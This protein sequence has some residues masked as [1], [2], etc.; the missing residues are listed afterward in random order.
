VTGTGIHQRDN[1]AEIWDSVSLAYDADQYWRLPENKAN[2][3]VLLT[4]IGHAEGKQILEMGCGSGYTSMALAQRGAR[5]TLL[6]LSPEAL[7]VAAESFARAG[8]PPPTLVREDALTTTL[9]ANTFDIAWNGGV[10]EHFFDSGKVLLIRQMLRVVK[11]GGMVII[12]VPNRLC[13]YFQ[14]IQAWK[15]LRGTWRYG[16]ED[17]MSPGRLKR[18][19]LHAGHPPAD[20]YAY[21]PVV[22]WQWL[23]KIGERLTRVLG[24]ERLERH[25]QRVRTGFVTIAV[26]EKKGPSA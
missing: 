8:L 23:P 25:C 17:D 1:V 13:W 2:L 22:G 20:A 24:G 26:I 3:E 21:N 15:K 19:C 11:P 4:H 6:D 7:R 14:I 18:L 10:I 16:F 9:P 5:C 12:L